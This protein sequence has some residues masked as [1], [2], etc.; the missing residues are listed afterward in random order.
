MWIG[1]GI[2]FRRVGYLAVRLLLGNMT[3]CFTFYLVRYTKMM[4]CTGRSVGWTMNGGRDSR[5]CTSCA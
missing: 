5:S 3:S 1:T 2:G 4:G